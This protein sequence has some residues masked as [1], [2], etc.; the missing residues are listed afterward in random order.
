MS[1][2]AIQIDDGYNYGSE[3]HY[4]SHEEYNY[5][6]YN[7]SG[8]DIENQLATIE[9]YMH[10]NKN[11]LEKLG[12]T[13]GKIYKALSTSIKFFSEK[14]TEKISKQLM[15]SFMEQFKMLTI[16]SIKRN[17]SGSILPK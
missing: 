10:R 8:P 17:G 5:A 12:G 13:P 3:N 16:V 1:F 9:E 7:K 6:A 11:S 14:P 15:R 2:T 4:E